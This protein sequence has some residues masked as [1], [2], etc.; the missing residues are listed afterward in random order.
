MRYP[1]QAAIKNQEAY[2]WD[3]DNFRA[4]FGVAQAA[5]QEKRFDDC[6]GYLQH[7]EAIYPYN[8]PALNML[9]AAYMVTG[10]FTESKAVLERT[11]FVLPDFDMAK[12]NLQRVNIAL[13]QQKLRLQQQ[14]AIAAQHGRVSPP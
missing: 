14:R 12:Q 11:L 7:F 5:Y 1:A 3:K 10:R 2:T 8:A 6:I 9:A 4:V 13:R